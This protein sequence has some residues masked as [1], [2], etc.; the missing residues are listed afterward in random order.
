MTDG[1]GLPDDQ[2]VEITREVEIAQVTKVSWFDVR[3]LMATAAQSFAA[4]VVGP[5]TGRREI[6]AALAPVDA[7]IKDIPDYTNEDKLWI[8][9]V[10]DSGDGWNATHSVAWLIGRNALNLDEEEL[11]QVQQPI[12]ANGAEDTDRSVAGLTR[13]EHG[14][15]LIL[16]GDQV[17]PTA[18]KV[19]YQK[20]F[21]DVFRS[22]RFWQ[23]PPRDVYAL[24]GNH[25]WYD[26]LTSFVRLFCQGGKSRRWIGAWKT[27]QH[28][29]YFAIPLPHGW[30]LWAVDLSLGDDLDPPQQQY[31]REQA[32]LLNN[33]DRVI[34][35]LPEPI[36]LKAKDDPAELAKL[37]LIV[38]LAEGGGDGDLEIMQEKN[39]TVPLMLTGDHHYYAR[40]RADVVDREL[41]RSHCRDYVICGGGGAFGLGTLHTPDELPIEKARQSAGIAKLEAVFPSREE[42][43]K[44]RRGVFKFPLANKAFSAVVAGLAMITLWLLSAA[45]F[46]EFRVSWIAENMAAAGDLNGLGSII[47]K[48]AAMVLPSVGLS[49]WV[50]VILAGF[51]AFGNAG[52]R[53]EKA[54]FWA[55]F[56]GILHGVLQILGGLT[57]VWLSAQLTGYI[58]GAGSDPQATGLVVASLAFAIA[59]L[60][61]GFIFGAYLFLSHKFLAMHDQ[62]VFSAQG[63]EE[64]KSFLRIRIDKDGLTVYP[65]GLRTPS[66]DWTTAPGVQEIGLPKSSLFEKVWKIKASTKQSRLF[67]P[68]VPLEPHLIEQPF[69][70]P[71]GKR[72]KDAQYAT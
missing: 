6:M 65:I 4:T 8:D 46:A 20:R 43:I 22:A 1:K 59:F 26:G 64:F 47:A 9:Y 58:P 41:G 19:N 44:A 48:A 2:P 72:E 49:I 10:A 31:F 21:V 38:K 18:T 28:R 54:A 40:H 66:R 52:K 24:P 69:V 34:L 70:I 55:A 32:E 7:D 35:C 12:P 39:I 14:K 16:G 68:V 71:N 60:L 45:W 51:G 15:L 29:S 17:Y 23:D 56:S 25:D 13:L 5:M 11:A 67:D 27:Q 63:I 61:C 30:W 53:P 57:S 37:D 62:E 36:W 3:Q 50:L 33:N 42:S